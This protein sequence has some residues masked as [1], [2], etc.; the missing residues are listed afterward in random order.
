MKNQAF[1]L[2]EQVGREQN[3]GRLFQSLF[4]AKFAHRPKPLG[5][6]GNR[7]RAVAGLIAS[8]P[9]GPLLVC[10]SGRGIAMIRFLRQAADLEAGFVALSRNFETT[11]DDNAARRVE[12]EINRFVAGEVSALRSGV[13]LSLVA[14][15]FQRRVLE[16]LLEVGPGAILTYSS[17]AAWAGAPQAP[18]AVGG[19]MHDNPIPV[20]VPCHRVV[21]SDLSLGGYG[22]GLDVKRKLLQMEGFSFTSAGLVAQDGAV[23]GHRSSRIFCRPGCRALARSSRANALLFRDA[24]R[25]EQAGMRACRIC[26]SEE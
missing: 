11:A 8:S 12:E 16:L 25:A 9:V 23:W 3:P 18:R 19:A 13:D 6:N 17:L 1:M 21:R 15:P 22:G 20:Y 24:K 10:V 7:P 26:R 5:E 2:A 14:G 4:D